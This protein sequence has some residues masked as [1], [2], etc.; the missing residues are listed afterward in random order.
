MRGHL[1]WISGKYTLV[2]ERDDD[3][4]V[5]TF[6]K[7]NIKGD[8]SVNEAGV[9]SL[10]NIIYYSI[11]DASDNYEPLDVVVEEAA[12]VLEDGRELKKSIKNK[13]EDNKYQYK[14]KTSKE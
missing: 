6:D 12:Y 7:D 4:S 3:T 10:A 13:S 1:P 9:K 11:L 2:I 5:Y 14:N 8:F